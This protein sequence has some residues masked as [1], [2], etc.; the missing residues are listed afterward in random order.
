MTKPHDVLYNKVSWRLVP[1]L[2]LCF[3]VAY[4]DRV[5]TQQ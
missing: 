5:K 4:M 3:V 2:L 1:F